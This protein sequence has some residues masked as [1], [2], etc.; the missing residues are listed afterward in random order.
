MLI[1]TAPII[2]IKAQCT[3]TLGLGNTSTIN[4]LNHIWE[5]YSYIADDILTKIHQHIKNIWYPPT[6]I[7]TLF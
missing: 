1:N 2:Y 4:L 3:T 5:M 6:H 7:K